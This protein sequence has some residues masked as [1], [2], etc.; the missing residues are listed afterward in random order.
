LFIS[1][2]FKSKLGGFNGRRAKIQVQIGCIRPDFETKLDGIGVAMS[3]L[4]PSTRFFLAKP[5][6]ENP[7]KG[8]CG[9]KQGLGGGLQPSHLFT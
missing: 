1:N 9:S 5:T 7:A 4:V 8:C 3:F 2:R 6:L